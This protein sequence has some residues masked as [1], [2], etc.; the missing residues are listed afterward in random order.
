L[1]AYHYLALMSAVERAHA[2]ID[3]EHA[4]AGAQLRAAV[5]RQLAATLWP[6]LRDKPDAF[7]EAVAAAASAPDREAAPLSVQA[8]RD[9]L[10]NAVRADM[11]RFLG[12]LQD[13]W[14][15]GS[16]SVAAPL[17]DYLSAAERAA[18]A[19]HWDPVVS[20]FGIS[21]LAASEIALAERFP[22]DMAGLVHST[23]LTVG[24][25]DGA[26]HG[27]ASPA[28]A[29]KAWP[30]L[31]VSP[32]CGDEVSDHALA[33]ALDYYL[34]RVPDVDGRLQ[35][36]MLLYYSGCPC[37]VVRATV[38]GPAL[39]RL[40]YTLSTDTEA[41]ALALPPLAPLFASER[42]HLWCLVGQLWLEQPARRRWSPWDAFWSSARISRLVNRLVRNGEDALPAR[43]V[44]AR[45]LALDERAGLSIVIDPA[46][47]ADALLRR[48]LAA[49]N[50]TP[51]EQ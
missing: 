30:S 16:A 21:A 13:L 31:F 36:L 38:L 18:L 28:R 39:A 49:A 22:A 14:A 9:M 41:A 44:L 10:R 20:P 24:G 17:L 6:M 23:A 19:A 46:D 4:E 27:D 26:L 7:W 50:T 45:W 25:Y 47:D 3:K 51:P 34:A 29:F 2:L 43:H 37:P 35:I 40:H 8:L 5:E 32:E 48:A 11:A 12:H 33:H 42:Y 1:R 15:F